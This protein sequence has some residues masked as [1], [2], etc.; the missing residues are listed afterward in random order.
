MQSKYGPET[1]RVSIDLA[2]AHRV[3]AEIMS[4]KGCPKDIASE[5]ADHLVDADQSG[6]ESHG[7]W[8]VLQYADYYDSGYLKAE[9]RPVL[10]QNDRGA[11]QVSGRGGIGIPAMSLAARDVVSR[12]LQTGLAAVAVQ[13]V[14][15]TG[16]IGAFAEYAGQKGCLAIVIGGGGRK[17]WRQVAPYGGRKAILPTNPYSIGIPGGQRGPVVIDFATAAAAAGWVYG[18]RLA[19]A[20]LPDGILIDRKGAP[21]NDPQAYFDGGALLTAGGAKGYAMSVAAEMIA[22][23]LLGPATTECNWLMLAMDCTLYQEPTRMQEI[24]EE[25]LA[26]LRAC[27]PAPGFT[28]VEVPGEREAESRQRN[29]EAPIHLPE[30]TWAKIE[31]LAEGLGVSTDP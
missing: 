2:T 1:K 25:I 19:G 26:E 30:A 9:V 31:I 5:V 13:H 6:V 3:V 22:E 20:K 10:E 18:A 11:W 12:A 21:T 24:A 27:P 16:R 15:H 8:R 4:A 14:G 29:L 7:I 23:A 17:N 28:K